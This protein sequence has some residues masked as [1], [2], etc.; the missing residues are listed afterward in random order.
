MWRSNIG[1]PGVEQTLLSWIILI[2]LISTAQALWYA[3]IHYVTLII[4]MR[5]LNIQ[6]LYQDKYAERTKCNYGLIAFIRHQVFLFNH[7]SH[8]SQR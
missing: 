6:P 7:G 4:P 8:L 1:P 3:F 2:S 5:I